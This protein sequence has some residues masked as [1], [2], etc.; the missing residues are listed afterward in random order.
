MASDKASSS[1]LSF[2]DNTVKAD[3][4]VIEKYIEL[5]W[6]CLIVILYTLE[7][8]PSCARFQSYIRRHTKSSI[9]RT[10]LL[11]GVGRPHRHPHRLCKL[12]IGFGVEEFLDFLDLQ[13]P[14]FVGD[15]LRNVYYL[16]G[17]FHSD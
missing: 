5:A 4:S 3:H 15:D 14:I 17:L 6:L 13:A 7:A 8:L 9:R 10:H 16:V 11:V 12:Q 1:G 2:V